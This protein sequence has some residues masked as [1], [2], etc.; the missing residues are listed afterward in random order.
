[1]K[2]KENDNKKEHPIQTSFI[3]YDGKLIEQCYKAGEGVCF[4]I[5]DGKKVEYKRNTKI[6]DI[7]YEPIFAE[8]IEKK[9]I[10]LPTKAEEYGTDEQLDNEIKE[11]I[12]KWL[13]IPDDVKQFALW[14]IKRSWVYERFHTLNYLRALGD[15]GQGKTRFLDVLGHIHYKPI[16]TSGA[17]TSAPVFR[18]IEKWKG[19]LIM[20]EAD[21]AKSD[22]AQDIIKIINMGYEDGKF[23]MR[24]EQNNISNVNF[25]NPYC[26]K[27]L[28]TRKTFQD[29]AVES[30]CITQVMKGT[31]RQDIPFNLNDDFFKTAQRLRNKLLMWR[32]RNF[33]NIDPNKQ[34][35][36]GLDLEP[37]VKQIVNSFVG[38]FGNDNVQLTMFKEFIKNHQE[39]LIDERRNS[40]AGAIVGG[41]HSLLEKG[42]I[43]ISTQDIITECGLT[44]NTGQT[45]K[46]RAIS[47]TLKSLGFGK[48]TIKRIDK[49]VKRCVPLEVGVVSNLLKRYGY[50]VSVVTILRESIISVTNHPIPIQS[51]LHNTCYNSNN[52]TPFPQEIEVEKVVENPQNPQLKP[53]LS[54]LDIKYYVRC[55]LCKNS[56]KD[57]CQ[58][59]IDGKLV[60]DECAAGY[61]G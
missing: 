23:V 32:F 59:E 52:V 49:I 55:N 22:E 7:I 54:K 58:N 56:P 19:T 16:A 39:E 30:R 34:V 17:T 40:W 36:L 43:N 45:L 8:E 3:E 38:L 42:E 4:A 15:T 48:T 21:F 2:E 31:N 35:D 46:P 14:N 12:T 57:G 18:M 41:I 60:C 47:S 28:A 11:Y 29:K 37:R 25:F 10:L 24:C 50:D 26:P 1:M 6:N 20:D 13:D 5:W 61:H 51:A 53:I 9:A 33:N 27:I 44:N